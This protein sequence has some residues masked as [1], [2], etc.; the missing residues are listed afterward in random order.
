MKKISKSIFENNQK[1]IDYF[2]TEINIM[3]NY[4][5]KNILN[6]IDIM[7]NDHNI[8]IITEYCKDGDL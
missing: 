3:K 2:I 5:H 4:K 1:S 7:Y 6:A 8:F